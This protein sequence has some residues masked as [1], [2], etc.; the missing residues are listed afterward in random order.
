VNVKINQPGEHH[1]STL[2]KSKV[3]VKDL[4]IKGRPLGYYLFFYVRV[5][6]KKLDDTESQTATILERHFSPKGRLATASSP[7]SSPRLRLPFAS[8]RASSHI[9]NWRGSFGSG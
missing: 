4:G 9:A 3:R 1:M 6:D 7:S 5:D 8:L 2:R